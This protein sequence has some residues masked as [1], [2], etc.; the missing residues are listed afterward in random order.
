MDLDAYAVAVAVAEIVSVARILNDLPGGGVDA[1]AGHAGPGG[2]NPGALGLQHDVVDLLHLLG[3]LAHGDGAGH[4]GTVPPVDAAE[5][6]G[7]EATWLHH[8]V[9]GNAVG[10]ASVGAGHHNGLEGHALGAEAQHVVLQFGGDLLL[11]HAGPDEFQDRVKGPV[12]DLLGLDHPGDLLLV[13]GC[14]KPVHQLLGRDQLGGQALLP[15][16]EGRHGHV[17]LLKA[18]LFDAAAVD[19]L[20]DHGLV[21]AVPIRHGDGR[22]GDLLLGGLDVPGVGEVIGLTGGDKGD[23]LPVEAHG[24]ELAGGAGEHHSVNAV[25]GQLGRNL[26]QMIHIV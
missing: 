17:F 7:K 13:L 22:A 14:P 8:G 16:V 10:Q 12:G 21:V 19:D 25:F 9:A 18:Q 2:G 1:L 15:V 11:R 20:L 3:G 23:A 26:F 5:V 4:V 6:H 24:I